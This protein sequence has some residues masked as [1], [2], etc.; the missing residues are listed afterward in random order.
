[1]EETS[2]ESLFP[3]AGVGEDPLRV[4]TLDRS[5]RRSHV[6][7]TFHPYQNPD[8]PEDLDKESLE[9]RN[10]VRDLQNHSTDIS[11]VREYHLSRHDFGRLDDYLAEEDWKRVR[12]TM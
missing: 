12:Y 9:L 2:E 11:S 8:A 3:R 7:D 5:S 6:G 1:M 10:L 4:I